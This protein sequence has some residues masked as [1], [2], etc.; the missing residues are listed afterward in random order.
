[1]LQ[2]AVEL[3]AAI[4][5]DR[6]IGTGHGGLPWNAP[7]PDRTHLRTMADGQAILVGRNTY[8]EM[9]GWFSQGSIPLVLTRSPDRVPLAPPARHVASLAAALDLLPSLPRPKLVV[10]GGAATFATTL[11]FAS[12]IYLTHIPGRHGG[13]CLFPPL[14]PARWQL[15]RQGFLPQP[16]P[17]SSSPLT[18]SIFIPLT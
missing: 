8:E 6:A 13:T 15:L 14:D 17:P 7:E 9:R 16:D 10:L 4:D 12:A 11:P 2:P 18:L 1:M 5:D 3:V